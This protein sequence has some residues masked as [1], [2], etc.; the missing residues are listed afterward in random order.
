MRFSSENRLFVVY[1]NSQN[2]NESWKLKSNLK[3]ISESVN[4]NLN[5][6]LQ[7]K[8]IDFN[9]KGKKYTAKSSLIL[10]TNE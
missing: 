10:I 3:K 6:G 4:N 9:F 1:V 7:S 8:V 2:Y 5:D